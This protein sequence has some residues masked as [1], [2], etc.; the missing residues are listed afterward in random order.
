MIRNS[1]Y[2]RDYTGYMALHALNNS[3]HGA[4]WR[5]D[6]DMKLVLEEEIRRVGSNLV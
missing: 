3:Q 4:V 6:Q 2:V 5:F 1:H